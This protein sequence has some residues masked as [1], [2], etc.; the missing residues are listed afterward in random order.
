LSGLTGAFC[1]QSFFLKGI[2]MQT[3]FNDNML[4][5]KLIGADH[6]IPFSNFY[7]PQTPA[8]ELK[9][10]QHLSPTQN[11]TRDSADLPNAILR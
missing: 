4:T 6:R 8:I 5:A 9:C 11:Q 7:A 10:H 3:I 2:K 1:S